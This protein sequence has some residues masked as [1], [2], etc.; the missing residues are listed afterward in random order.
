MIVIVA[1][2]LL[3]PTVTDPKLSAVGV[4]PTP[5]SARA[6]KKTEKTKNNPTN[7]HTKCVLTMAG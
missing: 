5:A 2:V 3:V 7:R 1:A 6:G 4:I